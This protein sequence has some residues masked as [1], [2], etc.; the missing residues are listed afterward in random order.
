MRVLPKW[1]RCVCVGGGIV[2]EQGAPHKETQHWKFI[3]ETEEVF[4]SYTWRMSLPSTAVL[5][6]ADPEQADGL[7]IPAP[8]NIH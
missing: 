6:Q 8:V 4:P 3:E 1:V 5:L 2:G 7:Q